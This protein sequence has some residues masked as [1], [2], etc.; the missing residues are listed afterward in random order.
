VN[1]LER[2]RERE[3]KGMDKRVM[4]ERY[5]LFLLFSIG[6]LKIGLM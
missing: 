4:G 3:N 1:E 2:E 6:T 5:F